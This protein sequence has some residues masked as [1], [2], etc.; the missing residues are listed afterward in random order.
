M[1]GCLTPGTGLPT[2]PPVLVPTTSPF[3]PSSSEEGQDLS[4]QDSWK[5]VGHVLI[6]VASGFYIGKISSKAL[7]KAAGGQGQGRLCR[8]VW[9]W[10]SVGSFCRKA[11]SC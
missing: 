9:L 11:G 5:A 8:R 10:G 7:F 2:C 1:I 4:P 6:W 3:L